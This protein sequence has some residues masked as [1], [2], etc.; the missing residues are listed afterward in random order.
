[1]EI[2]NAEEFMRKLISKSSD[3]GFIE[4]EANYMEGSSMGINILNGEVSSF[5]QSTDQGI[6]FRGLKNDQ[7]GYAYTSK[8]DD[9]AIEF[10]LNSASENC[11]VLDDEDKEFIYCDEKNSDLHYSQLSGNYHKNTYSKFKDVGL[12]IEKKILESDPR[13]VAVDYL[14]ISCC[15]GPSIIINSKG[16]RS[17]IDCDVV[18]IMAEA[19]G[20]E[21][22]VVKSG[23][24]YWFGND[25]DKFDVNDFVKTVKENVTDKFGAESIESGTYDIILENEAFISLFSTFLSS[26]SSYSMQKGLSLLKGK[27]GEI[28]AS[29]KLTVSEIPMYEKA[30]IKIPFD[31]EGVLTKQK[32]IIGN[33]VFNTAFYNLKTAYKE[34]KESTG[35]GFKGS[36]K[37]TVGIS[38]TNLVVK[39]GNLNEEELYSKL[40]NGILITDLMG[41]HAGVNTISGDF[42]L[43]CEGFLIK[44][45]KKD[46]AIEQITV[47]DN[48]YDLLKKIDEVGNDTIN[49]PDG[50]GEFFSPSILIKNVSIAGD[51]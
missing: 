51:K 40:D 43:L 10:L 20:S 35:N 27:E 42:S 32:D 6:A 25:I 48:F 33:G 19:R 1:M 26:F 17:F 45:G 23:G 14:S 13:I 24:H 18:T 15:T 38:F 9:D 7:M 36:Y 41:L 46:R 49:V 34:N 8:M 47:S 31:S 11:D 44:D 16:L 29:D 37:S 4:A 2:N 30:L 5:E 21:N 3:Y 28:I 22:D 12:E 50:E 39:E